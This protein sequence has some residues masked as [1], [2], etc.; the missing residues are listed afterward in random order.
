MKTVYISPVH[1]EMLTH[2]YF[3]VLVNYGLF[4]ID[5][6][7]VGDSKKKQATIVAWY[8][9]TVSGTYIIKPTNAIS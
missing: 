1:F 9:Y 8:K 2:G 4:Y 7:R 5:G 6:L 3:M